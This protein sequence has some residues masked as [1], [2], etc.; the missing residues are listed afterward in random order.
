MLDAALYSGCDDYQRR[1]I[2]VF[3]AAHISEQLLAASGEN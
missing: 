3:A 1:A 2:P